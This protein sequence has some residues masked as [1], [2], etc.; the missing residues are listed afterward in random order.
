MIALEKPTSNKN[1]Y[2]ESIINDT[3]LITFIKSYYDIDNIYYKPFVY[4]TINII[5][6][7]D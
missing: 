1:I 7:D 5:D 6:D 2:Y 4:D 3:E